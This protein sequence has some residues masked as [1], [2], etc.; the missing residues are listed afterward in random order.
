MWTRRGAPRIV[1]KKDGYKS[2]YIFS[3]VCPFSGDDFHLFM[4]EVN[5]DMMSIYLREL[6]KAYT[7]KTILLIMDQ[8]GWHRSRDL[9]I[10]K[11]IIIAFQPPYSPELNPVERLWKWI[12]K[13]AVH[14]VV[15]QTTNTL[16]DS[17]EKAINELTPQKL[18]QLCR[19]N[20]LL[21]IN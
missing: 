20:Y 1:I 10:P 9:V 3:S 18:A 8:A 19:C 13:E 2:F 5:T 16:M 12:R 14:N 11:N 4:P 17:I 21:S 15:Y 6:S 7:T